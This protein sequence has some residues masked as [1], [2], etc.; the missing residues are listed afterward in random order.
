MNSLKGDLLK[1]NNYPVLCDGSRDKNVTEQEVI[2][3]LF[4]QDSAPKLSY[5][6][7]Q[8]VE[9]ENTTGALLGINTAF[10]RFGIINVEK[11]LLGLN[12][13]CAS[14]NNVAYGGLDALIKDNAL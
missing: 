13:I 10:E 6:S 11:S 2:F 8:N 9:N 1:P 5:L 4:F 3:V 12:C 14:V 7:I